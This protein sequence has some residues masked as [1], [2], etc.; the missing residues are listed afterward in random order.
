MNNTIHVT[1]TTKGPNKRELFFL[2]ML[3]FQKNDKARATFLFLFFR[4]GKSINAQE[5]I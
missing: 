5:L 1:R 2:R 4:S 3:I